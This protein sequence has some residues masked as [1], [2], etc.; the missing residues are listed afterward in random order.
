MK[1]HKGLLEKLENTASVSAIKSGLI[2]VIPVLML[3]SAALVFEY[4]PIVAYQQFI[5]TALDGKL[6]LFFDLIYNATFGMLSVYLTCAV[7][8]CYARRHRAAGATLAAP[9]TSLLCFLI[10]S[11]FRV[12]NFPL[13]AL[14][15]KGVFIAIVSSLLA[16]KLLGRA[17]Q[18][19][20]RR[21][22]G[23]A[24]DSDVEFNNS[25]F[26]ILPAAAVVAL[27]TIV[28]VSITSLFEVDSFF[29]LFVNTANAL[30]MP[31]GRSFMSGLLL[32]L[33]SSI[34]WFFGIHGSNVL[35]AVTETLFTPAIDVNIALVAAG[36]APTEIFAK[37]FFDVFVLMGGCGTAICLL[38]SVLLF[39]KRRRNGRISK[40][41]AIPMLF[42]INE[43]M[44]FGYPVIYNATL[45]I[46]F[47]LTPLFSFITTY[48]AMRFGFVPLI[49]SEVNWTAPVLL[50][51][52]MA[53]GSL[54]GSVLQ[55][56]N[57]A[58]GVF[59]YRPFIKAY[60]RKCEAA[61]QAL[62]GEL[63]QIKMDSEST[64]VPVTLT[65]LTD[66]HGSLARSMAADLKYALEKRALVLFYQPQYDHHGS[67]VGIEALLRWRHPLYGMIYPPLIIQ[68]ARETDILVELEKYVLLYAVDDAAIIRRETGYSKEISVNI[69]AATLQTEAY[70]RELR[71]LAADGRVKPNAI[72]L[73]ITEQ[74]AIISNEYTAK[75]FQMI[76]DLGY[77]LAIDDFSMGHTSL[78]Y[79][80]ESR[81]DTVKL[82]G[83]LVREMLNNPRSYDIIKTITEL[84]HKLGFSVIAEYVETPEQVKMLQT[85]DCFQYQGYLFSAPIDRDSLVQRLLLDKQ[86][87]IGQQGAIPADEPT[88]APASRS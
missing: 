21:V 14:G 25:V 57:I 69:S 74:T 51:G 58:A 29:A 61:A 32:V 84:S 43:L 19:A 24:E 46:P 34:L 22:H 65:K 1:K 76:K 50:S 27:F 85:A 23:Y 31:L 56:F 5:E 82:D 49:T 81:F 35:E 44:I 7:S 30:F 45:L 15:V 73:E 42:N 17:S 26:V 59:I 10:C 72:C 9:I 86:N 54:A 67:C 52:Y 48:L 39:S 47:I 28:N 36:K 18:F 55:L 3:G 78:A 16:T 38:L 88:D 37:Q 33:V 70:M 79:L 60:D 41:A 71:T 63:T 87:V 64:L 13:D 8:F 12:R 75:L 4:F 80:Q 6:F 53:T 11:G 83:S 62:V 66:A 40:L 68:L 2:M 77:R 20:A